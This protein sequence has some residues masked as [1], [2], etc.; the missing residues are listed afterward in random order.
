MSGYIPRPMRAEDWIS[1]ISPC[2]A[3]QRS[4]DGLE[5]VLMGS[6]RLQA[7]AFFATLDTSKEAA[8]HDAAHH[9]TT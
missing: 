3:L 8:R 7:R 5:M 1:R 2:C 9:R 6:I 4:Q